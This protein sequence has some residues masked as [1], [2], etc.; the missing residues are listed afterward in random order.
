MENRFVLFLDGMDEVP[1]D[2]KAYVEAYI[3]EFPANARGDDHAS[4]RLL[5]A[6]APSVHHDEDP[7]LDP[8]QQQ[9]VAQ[10]RLPAKDQKMFKELML[11][12]ELQKLAPTRSMVISYVRNA[13]GKQSAGA[14][15]LNRWRLCY[16]AIETMITRLDKTL[17]DRRAFAAGQVVT[18]PCCS[19]SPLK[20]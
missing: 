15:K 5:G 2:L 18:W 12:P 17:A 3:M 13:S 14:V 6:V 20:P 16:S 11:D 9:D 1:Q 10:K 8:A 4:W 7:A 19:G